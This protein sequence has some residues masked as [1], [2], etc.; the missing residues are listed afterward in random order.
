M[1]V[2]VDI[3]TGCGFAEA[4]EGKALIRCGSMQFILKLTWVFYSAQLSRV[5]L[6][7]I[8][9]IYFKLEMFLV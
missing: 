2:R 6:D 7:T 1:V 9:L 8:H 4:L 5:A 3:R